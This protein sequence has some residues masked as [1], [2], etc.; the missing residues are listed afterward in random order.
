MVVLYKCA[1]GLVAT[2]SLFTSFIHYPKQSTNM[3][4]FLIMKSLKL[5]YVNR[6]MSTVSK[7]ETITVPRKWHKKM[8]KE[9]NE[10][11]ERDKLNKSY[12]GNHKVCLWN[13]QNVLD[14]FHSDIIYLFLDMHSF[15]Q[16]CQFKPLRRTILWVS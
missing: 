6:A 12:K 9:L 13:S 16:R 7:P 5:F 1:S 10:G 15:L 3:G 2:A 8:V 4:R 14:F 11:Q